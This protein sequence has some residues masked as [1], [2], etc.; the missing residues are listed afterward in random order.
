MKIEDEVSDVP[1]EKCGRMMVYKMGRFG[2]F[3][4]CPG[5]PACRNAKPIVVE[6][7]AECPK[8]G[9]KILE[10]KS[11]TGKIYFGCED[12]PACDYMTWDIPVAG[13]KCPKCGG[14]LLKKKGRKGGIICWDEACGYTK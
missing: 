2:K 13:E 7:G 8:C 6:T 12:N 4:A 5:F 9:K 1:C 14:L 10:K 3:L 11:K